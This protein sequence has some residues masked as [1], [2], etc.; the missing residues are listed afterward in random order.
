MDAIELLDNYRKSAAA[1][2]LHVFDNQIGC[3]D[4]PLSFVIC[5][6][7]AQATKIKEL[8]D[9]IENGDCRF[10]CRS[11]HL[12]ANSKSQVKRLVSQSTD[13]GITTYGPEED[14]GGRFVYWG[15]ECV[16]KLMPIFSDSRQQPKSVA[17]KLVEEKSR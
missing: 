13:K 17:Y 16:G 12:E 9:T 4:D 8:L 1:A 5:S 15:G 6:F 3:G 11:K 7:R 14:D 2:I 10:H